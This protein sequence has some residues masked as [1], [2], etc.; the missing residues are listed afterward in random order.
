MKSLLL[1]TVSLAVAIPA[2]AQQVPAQQRP[3]DTHRADDLIVTAP[4]RQS[5]TDVLQ[6][7]SVLSG[8]ALTRELRPTIGETL[9]RLP[10]V[11]ATSFGPNASRPILRGFSGDRVRIL[12][13]GIGSFDASSS[14]VDHAVVIDPL[15]AER[16]EVLRGPVALLYGS[17]AVGGVVNVI[18]ARIPR[19][20]PE[21]GYR[22]NAIA[23]YGS[24]ADQRNV[25]AS[26]DVAVGP[27][28]VVNVNGSYL[29]ADDTRIGGR[30]LS[31][32]ARDAALATG[33][34]ELAAPTTLRGRLPNSAVETWTA[35]VGAALVTDGGS[36]GVSYGHYDSLYGV[37]IRYATAIGQEAEAPR[38]DVRQDRVDLRAEVKTGGDVLEAIRLRIG[39]ADYRHDELEEDGA[40]GTTFLNNG[41]EARLEVVQAT[42]GG[43]TGASGVQY[44]GR[45]FEAI[46]EEAFLPPSET[47]Q[48]GLFTLQQFNLGA[49]RAEG[50][51]RY[52]RTSL[53]A[54]NV[55][56][57]PRFFA[58]ARDYDTF[59]GSLGASY[60][61]G[62]GIRIGLN[63]SRTE[64]A[65]SAEELFS[66]GAHAGTQ[67]YE[68]GNP[69]A[70][71]ETSWGLEATLHAHSGP[72]SLDASAFHNW[73]DGFIYDTQVATTVCEAAAAGGEVD[74]PC[75]QYQQADARYWGLEAD[76]ALRLGQVGG[77][78]LTAEVIGDY[79]KA[80]VVDRGPV[81]RIP[82][83]RLM[84]AL[85]ARGTATTARVEVERAFPQ[86]RTA[87]F[88]T[89]T[90]GY[91][92]VNASLAL[93][94]WGDDDRRSLLLSA[95][96]LFDVEARRHAS[97]LKDFAPLA[98]RDLRVTLRVGI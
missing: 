45:D 20:V 52:E 9:A 60:A 55:A 22:V 77:Q 88:E 38:I 74:L 47:E 36:L 19:R 98:G 85:E 96:N 29:K 56:D 93:R 34:P 58:G 35:G 2:A 89:T 63:G 57:A 61:L 41:T 7:T 25:A 10:G 82:P 3:R 11:S 14:S 37:P 97:V 42:R 78:V 53:T 43:W 66:N 15:L 8:E 67:A 17:S 59:S 13:D 6:G 30:V 94:P 33:D 5:E 46:G 81:P 21:A 12:T 28:F 68:L 27:Q 69:F 18:D 24:A 72:F 23:G 65:P 79:V 50:G 1:A 4:I 71:K 84:G 32:S 39:H 91:T 31:R 48:V 80:T 26:A 86:R 16:I 51:V 75:F 87:A 92:L 90:D 62:D 95:N 49:F 70:R 44:L 73:F 54:R 76:A 40:I 64:R 83:L